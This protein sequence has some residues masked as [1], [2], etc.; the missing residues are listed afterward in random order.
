[1]TERSDNAERLFQHLDDLVA[2]IID[3]FAN[4]GHGTVTVIETLQDVV[5]KRRLAYDRDP[6]PAEDVEHPRLRLHALDRRNDNDGGVEKPSTRSTSTIKSGWPGV[7]MRLTTVSPI[8]KETTAAWIV[9]PRCRSSSWL[10]V[11]VLPLSTLPR[12]SMT[13]ASKSSR[14]VRLVLPAS[15]WARQVHDELLNQTT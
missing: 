6:D 11:W 14:S 4:E 2:E 13:P 10:S 3:R 7:S 15:T 9:I 1:M 12:L 8:V 5:A